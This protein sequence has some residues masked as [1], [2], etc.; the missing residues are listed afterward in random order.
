MLYING[1][2]VQSVSGEELEVINPATNE[3][4]TK[5]AKGNEQDSKL[6]IEAA[7]K[8][9]KPWKSTPAKERAAF[10]KSAAEYLRSTID[11]L[12]ETVTKEMGK[13][14]NE[15]KGEIGLAID[16]LEWYG[17][18]A[19][20]V[21]GETIPSSHKDK[22]LMVL[23]EPV[24]VTAAVTP[25][26]FPVAMITRKL[27]PALAAGCPVVIKPAS[28]TPLSALK[29]FEAFHEVGLPKGVA[30]LV[31]GSASKVVGEMTRNTAVRKITFTGSTEVGKKLI[32]DSADTVKKI[33]MELG[34]HAPFI[35]F[36][37]ADLDKAVEGAVASKFRNAGQTCIC[38]NRIYVQEGVA[39]EFGRKF[40]EKVSALKIGNG[41]EEGVAIGPLIDQGALSK[42]VEHIS[43][44]ENKGAQIL[45]GGKRA[46]VK[47]NEGCF[48]EPTVIQGATDEMIISIEETFGPVAPIYT[49]KTREEVIERANHQEYGLAAYCFTKDLSQAYYMMEELEYG[50]VGI[51]DP[52]PTTA[53]APFGGVKESGIGREGGHHGINEYLEDKFVS[54]NLS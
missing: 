13:P 50:I 35:V 34:G 28:A 43:D 46:E 18:E 2:W 51:N 40:A 6:A 37:D 44:A 14:V 26:N 25:W 10:L 48:F 32:R 31:S 42:V 30:N 1:E 12:A 41:L 54:L 19:K 5:V 29:V 20:R 27:A 21:Y 3:V 17:E 49:F 22:R 9:F 47:G 24:G 38:T 16:Y 33:S 15:A 39:E 52:I 11:D 7:E 36:D 4:I 53:Q 8:A 45:C 23:K